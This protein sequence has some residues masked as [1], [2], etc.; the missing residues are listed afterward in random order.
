MPHRIAI[1]RAFLVCLLALAVVTLRAPSL[2]STDPQNATVA[3]HDHHTHT[4]QDD[5][6]AAAPVGSDHDRAHVGDHSHDTPSAAHLSPVTPRALKD[7]RLLASSSRG[8]SIPYPP[9]DRPPR[10]A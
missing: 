4:D 1:V 6:P 7:T 10:M 5:E 9:G 2:V 8:A 3:A